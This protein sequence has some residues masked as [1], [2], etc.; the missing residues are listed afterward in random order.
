MG[1]ARKSRHD[2]KFVHALTHASVT[3]KPPH[4]KNLS[5]P[6]TMHCT[7]GIL[8]RCNIMCENGIK[9]QVFGL[10]YNCCYCTSILVGY[11]V[12]GFV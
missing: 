8:P 4:F 12:D 6:M 7:M 11:P 1:V 3:L 9:F 2:P 10:L 5:T